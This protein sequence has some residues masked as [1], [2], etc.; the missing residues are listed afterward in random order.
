MVDY[1]YFLKILFK[2]FPDKNILKINEEIYKSVYK[3][4]HMYFV[5]KAYTKSNH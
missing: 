4:D 1:H 2:G 3:K 5:V